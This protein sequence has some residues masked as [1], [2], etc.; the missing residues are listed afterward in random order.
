MSAQQH[1]PD[2]QRIARDWRGRGFSCDLWSDPPG[3]V[4]ADF[5]HAGDELVMLLEGQIELRFGGRVL[6][7][8][9]GEEVLIPAGAAHTVVNTGAARNRWLYGYRKT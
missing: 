7:P 2:R 9:V 8:A 5:V 1:N 6:R 4:W 3:Q